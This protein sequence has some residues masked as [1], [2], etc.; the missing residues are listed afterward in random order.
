MKASMASASG[1]F[2]T[3]QST[4]SS[5]VNSMAASE[6]SV[7][8]NPTEYRR[9][10]ANLVDSELRFRTDLEDPCGEDHTMVH[11]MTAVSTYRTQMTPVKIELESLWQVPRAS[12]IKDKQLTDLTR[13]AIC[14]K[15]GNLAAISVSTV[16]LFPASAMTLQ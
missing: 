8:S 10:R 16:R 15:R 3:M 1:N 9:P 4:F 11:D 12:Y 13:S 6:S 5:S 2:S 14:V 7:R